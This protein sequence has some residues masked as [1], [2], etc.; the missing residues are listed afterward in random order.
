MTNPTFQKA[1]TPPPLP[2]KPT[3]ASDVEAGVAAPVPEDFDIDP[4]VL[5]SMKWYHLVLRILYCT[6]AI[7]L[8]VTAGLSLTNQKNLGLIFFAF[9]VL[10]FSLLLCCFEVALPVSYS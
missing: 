9:Y 6:A 2:N 8:G 3:R 1:Y 5:K 7:F 4:D 10:F